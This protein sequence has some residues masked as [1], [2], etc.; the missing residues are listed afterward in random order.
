MSRCR[1]VAAK[2]LGVAVVPLVATPAMAG[3][4]E[5]PDY[6]GAGFRA[7]YDYA[8]LN[9]LPNLEAPDLPIRLTG[10]KEL[11]AR[12]WFLAFQRG[13]QLRPMAGENLGGADGV[14]MQHDAAEA[15]LALKAVAREEGLRFIVSSAYRSPG[16][17]RARFLEK[18]KGTTDDE[19]LLTLRWYSVPGT[20]KHHGGYALDFRYR[21]GTF[22]EFRD[23]PDFAWLKQDNFAVPKSHGLIPSYPDDVQNQGPNPEPWEFVWVGSGLIHCG[24][25]QTVAPVS[26]PQAALLDE[27]GLCP[28]GMDGAL[29]PGWLSQ[30]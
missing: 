24:I 16:A 30:G 12:I 9:T 23:T 19:I 25:P 6:D 27:I 15:W 20:S 3:Q 10:D 22:G 8:V 4:G 1:L 17:Q 26:G 18:L 28:G 13:Y 29:I 7:L 21:D 14:V 5:L 11:D 2:L